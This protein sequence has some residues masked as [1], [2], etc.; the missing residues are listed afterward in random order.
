VF[1]AL[2]NERR[3]KLL[4]YLVSTSGDATVD[5]LADHLLGD[6]SEG[7]EGER[8]R[9]RVEIHHVHVPKL[10]DSGLVSCNGTR[11]KV[12]LTPLV[13]QLPIWTVTPPVPASDA[14]ASSRQ[15]GD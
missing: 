8:T 9:C 5:E 10:E 6:G 15:A 7:D 1:D 2:G 12:T 14:T 11:E 4:R 3:R 13:S